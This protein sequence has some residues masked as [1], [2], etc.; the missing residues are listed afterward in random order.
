[1]LTALVLQGV[2]AATI[3]LGVPAISLGL[4]GDAGLAEGWAAIK[5]SNRAAA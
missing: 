4:V 1:V 2:S 5:G 3:G